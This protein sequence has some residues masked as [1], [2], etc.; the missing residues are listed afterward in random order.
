MDANSSGTTINEVPMSYHTL[1]KLLILLFPFQIVV[2]NQ[3]FK[4]SSNPLIKQTL[5]IPILKYR[6]IIENFKP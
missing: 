5:D 2:L 6:R 1:H 4:V 3:F